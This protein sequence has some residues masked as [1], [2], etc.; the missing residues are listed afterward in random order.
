MAGEWSSS[1]VNSEWTC[2]STKQD[3]K[4]RPEGHVEG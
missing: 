1:S 4:G 3:Y 2:D